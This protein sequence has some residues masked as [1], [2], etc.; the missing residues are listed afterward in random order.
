M[1]STPFFKN[2]YE[3]IIPNYRI[4]KLLGSGGMGDV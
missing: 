1:H 2:Q 3:P 4:I